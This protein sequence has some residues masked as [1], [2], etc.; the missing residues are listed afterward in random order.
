MTKTDRD[1]F[2]VDNDINEE[3]FE[4]LPETDIN[5][6]Y[7]INFGMAG[8]F[9]L[10][11]ADIFFCEEGLYI[12]EYGN[13]TPLFGLVTQRHRREAEVMQ[14]IYEYHG[15]DEILLQADYVVWIN[16]ENVDQIHVH[17]GGRL[18]RAKFT[19]STNDGESYSYRIHGEVSRQELLAN[20]K[21]IADQV[22]LTV[23]S[24][25]GYGL[26]LGERLR[27]LLGG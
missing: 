4:D 27:D 8:S 1:E 13:I 20:I 15:I 24:D 17:G 18:G 7:H 10:R 26:V 11:L 22:G 6:I 5:V 16:Y 2:A 25:S 21:K 9:P 3:E 14:T 12:T 19:A 23:D